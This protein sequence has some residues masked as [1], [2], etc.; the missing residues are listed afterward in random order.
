MTPSFYCIFLMFI[1]WMLIMPSFK[2]SLIVE[3]FQGNYLNN[4]PTDWVF[5]KIFSHLFLSRYVLSKLFFCFAIPWNFNFAFNLVTS[6]SRQKPLR[7]K[8]KKHR[9]FWNTEFYH[10]AKF[11][12]CSCKENT[13]KCKEAFQ[14]KFGVIVEGIA[15]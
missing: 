13:A 7:S 10:P 8:N 4:S 9:I 6:F 2:K 3:Q 15:L 11:E 12:L 14:G 5:E 1:S